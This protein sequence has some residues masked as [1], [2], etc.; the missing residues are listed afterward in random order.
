MEKDC[1]VAAPAS[2]LTSCPRWI[3]KYI[4]RNREANEGAARREPFAPRTKAGRL[5]TRP[6]ASGRLSGQVSRR[7]GHVKDRLGGCVTTCRSLI[8]ATTRQRVGNRRGGAAG[9]AAG[10]ARRSS[11]WSRRR[12]GLHTERAGRATSGRCRR[13]GEE[14]DQPMRQRLASSLPLVPRLIDPRGMTVPME[15]QDSSRRV[16]VLHRGP[17]P[18]ERQ[19]V[20]DRA[21]LPRS[22]TFANGNNVCGLLITRRR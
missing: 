12:G 10:A 6:V 16:L 15:A 9:P 17:L 19:R 1:P 8:K 11:A 3:P 20:V 5:G 13:S 4:C 18:W 21:F 7:P 22:T 2:R 14:M